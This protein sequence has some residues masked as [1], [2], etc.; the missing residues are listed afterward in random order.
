MIMKGITIGATAAAAMLIPVDLAS[1]QGTGRGPVASACGSEIA[2]YCAGEK[3]GSGAV[4]ACL[5]SHRH[6]LSGHCRYALNN[7]GYGWRWR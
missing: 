5:Q 3:H 4:R 2:R 1:A 7:T 6:G